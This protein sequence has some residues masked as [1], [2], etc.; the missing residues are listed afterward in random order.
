MR[1]ALYLMGLSVASAGCTMVPTGERGASGDGQ[2]VSYS[3]AEST[4]RP[5]PPTI[6]RGGFSPSGSVCMAK[7]GETGSRFTP[8]PD[9]HFGAG[10]STLGAVQLASVG[11][12][13]GQ[14]GLTNTGPVT[15]P[16]AQAFAGWARFGVDRAAREILGSPLIRIETM[17]TYSCRNIAGSSRRSAHSTGDAMDVSA[18]VLADGSRIAVDRDW[19]TGSSRE[20]EFLRVIHKSA[21][22]RFGTV[23]GPDYNAAH[24]DHFHLEIKQGSTFCR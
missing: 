2:G 20:R 11:G 16:T 19:A 4:G 21:C 23:L 10:C 22:K 1:Y 14:F 9:Q 6:R 8:V 24:R 12:D 13:M 17:G 5:V 7:L 18:F 3:R 15:C